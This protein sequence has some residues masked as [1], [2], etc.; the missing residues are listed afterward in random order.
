MS[1]DTIY[2]FQ[3]EVIL[4]GGSIAVMILFMFAMVLYALHCRY[5]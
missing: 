3:P 1:M 2:G 5:V 4:V